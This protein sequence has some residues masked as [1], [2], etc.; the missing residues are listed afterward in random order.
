MQ[1]SDGILHYFHSNSLA[2]TER[3]A[4][5]TGA[6]NIYIGRNTQR[7]GIYPPVFH[8]VY[9]IVSCKFI[10]GTNLRN[11]GE[12]YVVITEL[13]QS[14][15]PTLMWLGRE[16]GW[17]IYDCVYHERLPCKV[18]KS[19]VLHRY[20]NGKNC[21]ISRSCLMMLV[22]NNIWGITW[23]KLEKSSALRLIANR[24]RG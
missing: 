3:V 6:L 5:D 15:I 10:C 9:C 19:L 22:R 23:T 16:E 11:T 18:A 12:P 14:W 2:D 8:Q 24:G 4:L 21:K 20:A 17:C 7:K 13:L 1:T